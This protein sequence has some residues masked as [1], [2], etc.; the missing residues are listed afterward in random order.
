MNHQIQHFVQQAAKKATRL[1]HYLGGDFPHYYD[2]EAEEWNTDMPWTEAFWAGQF[3]QL[4]WLDRN[5]VLGEIAF[6]LTEQICRTRSNFETHDIGFLFHYSV[7]LGYEL[8]YET[9]LRLVE[10]AAE[11]LCSWYNEAGSFIPAMGA[12]ASG[13]NAGY[14]IID[15]IM[16]LQ[17]LL[18]AANSFD[19][20]RYLQVALE[21]ADRILATLV[22]SDGSTYQVAWYDAESGRVLQVGT[23]Q[24]A[25]HEGTWSRGQAWAVYGFASLYEATGEKRFKEAA[26][27]TSK[28]FIENLPEEG[29]APYD[30]RP[31]PVTGNSSV[32]PDSSAVAICAAGLL[33]F[34]RAAEGAERARAFV[35]A[36]RLL[37]SLVSIA[38]AGGDETPSAPGLLP[39][40]S[41][42][43]PRNLGIDT[44]TV[45]GDYFLLE[46]V[47]RYSV[48]WS[49]M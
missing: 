27:R 12:Q 5:E 17:L 9:D 45:Y 38:V 13:D 15:T 20:E 16:N 39:H 14:T 48:P 21:V 49:F 19:R 7:I 40:G 34:G 18:W 32:P 42:F 2:K 29:L 35:E 43:V 4:S 33:L 11:R 47:S 28:Y 3:W 31:G 24:G 10:N 36:E 26:R 8:G 25:R 44:Y 30:F 6:G 46:A 23:L 37:A 22:R 1:Y 41:Y